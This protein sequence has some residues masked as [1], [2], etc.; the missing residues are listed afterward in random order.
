LVDFRGK[1]KKER[2]K[3]G[4]GMNKNKLG[5]LST[6]LYLQARNKEAKA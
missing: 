6:V 4:S 2:K 1:R 5:R 3:E